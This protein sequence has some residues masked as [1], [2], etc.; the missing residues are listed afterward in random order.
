MFFTNA[1]RV[2]VAWVAWVAWVVWA[3]WDAALKQVCL[4]GIKT[5]FL[6]MLVEFGLLGVLGLL[7]MQ[8]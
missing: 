4:F 8:H 5:C 1:S 3:A 6:P 2:W 7:G